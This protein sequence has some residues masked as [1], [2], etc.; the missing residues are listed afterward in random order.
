[1]S[2]GCIWE[3]EKDLAHETYPALP[4]LARGNIPFLDHCEGLLLGYGHDVTLRVAA[5]Q[6]PGAAAALQVLA[7]TIKANPSYANAHII[8]PQQSSFPS[9]YTH[10]FRARGFDHIISY[11]WCDRKGVDEEALFAVL[12][13]APDASVVVIQAVAHTPSGY[14]LSVPQWVAVA[15]IAARKAHYVVVDAGGLGVAS[16]DPSL[17]AYA[18]RAL[19]NAHCEFATVLSFSR[20]LGLGGARIA[21]ALMFTRSVTAQRAA[22]AT[23]AHA[24][25][26]TWRYPVVSTAVVACAVLT[27]AERISRW[28][29][30]LADSVRAHSARREALAAAVDSALARI[31]AGAI[32]GPHTPSGT[33]N[34]APLVALPAE[35]ARRAQD[36]RA[37]ATRSLTTQI[38]RY[39]LT[40]LPR[41][42]LA[43][44]RSDH[45]IVLRSDGRLTLCGVTDAEVERVAESV[46]RVAVAHG[47][48]A[49]AFDATGSA[50]PAGMR[51]SVCGPMAYD[52]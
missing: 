33:P 25:L 17:D 35:T 47:I 40:G 11:S 18:V 1:M 36:A 23:L 4:T 24:A 44:L 15:Q 32:G 21:A 19:A 48:G 8:I 43:V 38:G 37:V 10:V 49:A 2:T 7:Q 26:T 29:T 27:D 12:K 34:G 3:T 46:A 16:G 13:A 22:Q 31:A 9:P 50:V 51:C 41:A 39:W 6:T 52:E 30:E 42:A 45:G 20:C 28:R 14:D 5:V